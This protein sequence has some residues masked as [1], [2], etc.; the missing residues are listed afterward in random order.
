MTNTRASQRTT[1]TAAVRAAVAWSRRTTEARA[2]REV[3]R[4][5]GVI[6]HARGPGTAPT[7]PSELVTFLR[8]PLGELLP[9]SDE[10]PALAEV[11]LL[12]AD[13]ELAPEAME[14]ACDYTEALFD[15]GCDPAT[16]WLPR[17]AWQ[18]A[19]QVERDT[20]HSLLQ[21]GDQRAYTSSRR[22]VVERPA[23][24]RDW[25]FD[26]LATNKLFAGARPVADYGAIPLD[27]RFGHG[28][29]ATHACW[30]AC[31]TC[32]WPMLVRPPVVACSYGPHDARFRL[33][34]RA[35]DEPPDL[36]STSTNR[37]RVPPPSSV[38]SSACVDPAVWRFV[39]IPGLPE[40]ALEK[41]QARFPG[42]QVQLW[43]LK[44]TF[45]ALVTTPT[46]LSWSVDVK[47]HADA[48]TIGDDPPAAEHIV[49]PDHR[50]RQL[51]DL[52]RMLPGKSVWTMTG[53]AREIGNR[54]RGGKQP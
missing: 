47:D 40:V 50:R 2:W 38:G 20:F 12:D 7:T 1:A 4:M 3:A 34:A 21:A 26:E 9:A 17:W 42:V 22:F 43:P 8:R 41:L 44:D 51:H 11:V 35:D 13:D 18:R 36:V 39:T 10:A 32:G 48:R 5:T 16:S 6:M 30:W 46:G 19:E 29:D 25:L 14:I 31:P 45:D 53:F 33:L 49:V 54:I 37:R 52:R 28:P 23:G 27:R 15:D 24:D